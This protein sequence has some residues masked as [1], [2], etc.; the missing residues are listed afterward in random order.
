MKVIEV[1]TL[2]FVWLIGGLALWWGYY[3]LDL[4]IYWT[5]LP[6]VPWWVLFIVATMICLF[7]LAV[8]LW[9]RKKR[10]SPS[11]TPGRRF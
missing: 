1:V 5:D 10:P 8:V 6:I 4:G 9:P 2:F 7:L 11:P 3:L